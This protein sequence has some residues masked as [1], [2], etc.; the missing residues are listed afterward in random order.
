MGGERVIETTPASTSSTR[1]RETVARL[2]AARTSDFTVVSVDSTLEN[3]LVR[4]RF[5]FSHERRRRIDAVLLAPPGD[6]RRGAVLVCPGRN[7]TLGRVTG[8][9]P[10]DY[11]DRN[12]AERLARAG[13]VTLTLDYAIS[14]GEEALLG[15]SGRS[16]IAEL[17]E[18]AAAAMRWLAGHPRADPDRLGVF[19][20]SLGAAVAL[21]TA[22]L[23]DRPV[24]VCAASH[25]GSYEVL[26]GSRLTGPEG[27]ALPGILRY[28]DLP[29][30]YAALAPAPLQVQ[31]GL[32]DPLLDAED[33][34][35]A[36]KAIQAAYDSA[37]ARAE[38]LALTMGYGTDVDEAARFFGRALAESQAS[39]VTVPAGRV[40][41]DVKSRLEIAERIDSSLASGSLTLGRFGVRVE[42]LAEPWT[43]ATTVAVASGSAALEIAFR[44]IGVAGR[45]VLVPANTFFASAASAIRA[46]AE[47]DFIDME[48]DGLGMDPSALRHALDRHDDVAAVVVV[49]LAG[50]VSPAMDEVLAE[51]A[52]RGIEVVE[53]AAHALGS[54]WNGRPAGSLARLGAFSLYPTKVATS[55]EG[56]LVTCAR[57]DD[58]DAARRYRDQGK[59]SFEANVHAFLGSNWRMSELHAAVGIAHLER[60]GDI[61]GER[62]A[63][64]ARYDD[65][66][67]R[68]PGLSVYRPPAVSRSN[69]YKYVALLD[70]DV[71]RDSLRQRLRER[72]RV[73]LSGGVYDT[74][75]P[76]QP[77]F[78]GRA[79]RGSYPNAEY[80]AGRH[81]CLPLFNGMTE[82]QQ[83]TVVRALR[84][85]LG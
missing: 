47:V 52:G 77:Y 25:L 27:G 58:A 81:I 60:F 15:L 34:A 67:S 11:P 83:L 76:Q 37:D 30:L 46:G 64:A 54:S 73:S 74:L 51:C 10:P 55:G 41:F 13:F 78:A 14:P 79:D 63:L 75:V 56:G 6:K 39:P 45:T 20:H 44:L 68:L 35:A 31:F 80:F 62:R 4:E 65:L 1:L 28:A 23:F 7:A 53:D 43:G 85:E 82:Q 49:H 24:P 9:E 42:E 57:P 33:A 59:A 17:A 84:T 48:L 19:G 2:I 18:E 40:S 72:H 32:D 36:G 21:H 61:V 29:Q 22:L 38:V 8:L 16:L 12:V 66:L 50:V 71:D 26:Y 5:V 3:E 70:D 69:F